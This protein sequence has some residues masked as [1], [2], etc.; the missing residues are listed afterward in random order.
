MQL[1]GNP[2]YVITVLLLI[3]VFSEWLG[4][5]KGFTF[6]GGVLLTIITAAIVSNFDLIPSNTDYPL[7]E[8]IFNYVAPIAIFFLMLDVKLKGLRKAGV[9]MITMFLVGSAGAII[10]T[11][12]S[13]YI[14]EPQQQ[15]NQSNAVAGMLTG[16]YVGGSANLNAIALHYG[17]NKDGTS[18][19]AINAADNI[20]STMW[21][22][23]MIFLCP[24]LQ[25]KFPRR[26]ATDNIN[27]NKEVEQL[28]HRKEPIN[29]TDLALL[30]ALAFGTLFISQYLNGLS[31]KKIPTILI[32]TTIALILAQIKFIQRLKGGK[33]MGYFFIL[34]FLAVVGAF[35]DL[36]ALMAK[37]DVALL[38]FTW[39]IILILIH[40]V[41]IYLVGAILKQD[42]YVIA[43]SSIA[44]IGGPTSSAAVATSLGR[45]DLRLPAIL[46]GTIGYAIGTYLGVMV[47]EI[48]K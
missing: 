13:Y 20:A 2:I 24:L 41:I 9:P 8:G 36:G 10:G 26:S 22:M 39:I 46:V 3:I 32:L 7:Y 43:I 5:K 31:N 45:S 6:L 25:R 19:A 1:L 40:G 28:D 34:I 48:L 44:G 47:A 29:V 18:F 17:V 15:V 35:C 16:T 12:L 42:W 27:A 38:L 23:L 33:V 4:A 11:F 37:G 30:L 14:V 21:T